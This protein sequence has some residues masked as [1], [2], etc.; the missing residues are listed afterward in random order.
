[1]IITKAVWP[2]AEQKTVGGADGA[3]RPVEL[4]H[5]GGLGVWVPAGGTPGQIVAAVAEAE[6]E[7]C[8]AVARRVVDE[9]DPQGWLVAE[10]ILKGEASEY[11]GPESAD[12]PGRR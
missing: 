7:R 8:A 11:A 4:Y 2:E 6:R 12:D 5:F 10:E 1:M 9:L 3:G